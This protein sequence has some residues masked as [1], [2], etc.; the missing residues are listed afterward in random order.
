MTG[1]P[2]AV[3]ETAHEGEEARVLRAFARRRPADPRYEW[4][5]PGQ[6]FLAQSRERGLLRMLRARGL[7]PLRDRD[8]L[9]VGC[10]TG[11][12]LRSLVQW[13][14]DPARVAAIDLIAERVAEAR[15]LCAPGVRIEVANATAIPHPDAAFD[16]VLQSTVFTSVLDGETRRRIAAEMLRVLR[17]GGAVLWYD[18]HFDNPRNADV[19]AV[20]PR[21]VRALFPGCRVSLRRG[22][23]APPLA[24]RLAPLSWMACHVLE[25]LPFLCTHHLGVIQRP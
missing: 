16:L 8:V 11:S 15:R 10:G 1:E 7:L 6:L 21:E 25:K 3:A 23:L 17:P 18:F 20:T 12:W 5:N 14:A 22:G 9:E 13:G 2:G 19:K 4:S 24:R